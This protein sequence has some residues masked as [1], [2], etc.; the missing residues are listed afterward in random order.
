MAR[1]APC[2]WVAQGWHC[3]AYRFNPPPGWPALLP[4][5]RPPAGWQPDPS[6]PPAPTDWT[7]WLPDDD[8]AP[9]P[10]PAVRSGYQGGS[11]WKL[12]SQSDHHSA[13][14][15]HTQM[16]EPNGLNESRMEV[17]VSGAS[18]VSPGEHSAEGPHP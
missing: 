5:W 3:M 16:C 8:P 10:T 1:I 4:D 2:G 11:V 7:W 18:S 13:H 9:R 6:W 12:P 15:A 14:S 17:E